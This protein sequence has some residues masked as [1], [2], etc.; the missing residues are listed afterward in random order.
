MEIE[1]KSLCKKKLK[2]YTKVLTHRFRDISPWGS[3]SP[4]WL[5]KNVMEVETYGLL[6]AV[7]CCNQETTKEDQTIERGE[8]PKDSLSNDLL[9][10]SRLK[11]GSFGDIPHSNCNK[12]HTIRYFSK[13]MMNNS[14]LTF[15]RM[16]GFVTTELYNFQVTLIALFLYITTS[17]LGECSISI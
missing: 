8:I 10:L 2:T 6:A 3:L 5:C 11:C 1:K 14:E 16:S 17:I 7:L 13:T 4:M 12:Y 15:N 9:S